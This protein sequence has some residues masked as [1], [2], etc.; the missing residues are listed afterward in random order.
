MKIINDEYYTP[1]DFAIQ[2]GIAKQVVSYHIRR[3]QLRAFGYKKGKR[4]LF[5]LIPKSELARFMARKR[6]GLNAGLNEAGIN[7]MA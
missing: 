4:T 5:T 1:Q 7:G 2:A 6:A 3:R